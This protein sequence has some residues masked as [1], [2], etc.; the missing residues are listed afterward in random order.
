SS[1]RRAVMCVAR[2]EGAFL[3][4]VGVCVAIHPGFVLKRNEGGMSNYGLHIKTAVPYTIALALLAL[5][6][7]RAALLYSDGDT[8]T[9]R[10]RRLLLAYSAVVLSV[11][12]STYVYSLNLVLKDLHFALGTALIVLVGVGSLWMY[13][14]WPPSM[15]IR[16]LL[17]FQLCGDLLALLSATGTVR[18]LFVAEILSNVGF[19]ALLIRTGRRIAAEDPRATSSYERSP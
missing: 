7:L 5:Y 18:A 13:R 3:F 15:G 19:A 12:L 4:F 17:L 6:S 14:Q 8:R 16:V 1:K 10:L 9:R 11:M 2:G